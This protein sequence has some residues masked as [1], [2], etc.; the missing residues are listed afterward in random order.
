MKRYF[1]EKMPQIYAEVA[2]ETNVK[3]INLYEAYKGKSEQEMC[4][5]QKLVSGPGWCNSVHYGRVE[6]M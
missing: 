2:K 6:I 5:M 4:D 1:G 3:Y